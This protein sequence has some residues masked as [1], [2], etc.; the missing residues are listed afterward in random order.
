MKLLFIT[1]KMDSQDTI[2]GFV[3]N[4]VS[5]FA[6]DWSQIDVICLEKGDISSLPDSVKVFSLGKEFGRSRLKYFKKFFYYVLFKTHRYDAVFVHM[7]QEYILLAGWWWWLKGKKVYLWRNHHAGSFLTD[8]AVFFCDKVFCTSK[9]SYT[10]K[11]KKTILMPVGIDL[12]KFYPKEGLA[13]Q[14]GSIL[15]LS[16]IS[17]VKKAHILLEA[18][19]LVAKEGYSFSANFYGDTL[20]KDKPYREELNDL[21]KKYNLEK[22]VEF[23]PGVPNYLTPDLYNKH[24]LFINLSS[25]GMYDKTIFEALA[26]GCPVLACNLNLI[27]QIDSDFIFEEDDITDLSSK[28]SNLIEMPSEILE[29][30]VDKARDFVLKMHSLDRLRQEIKKQIDYA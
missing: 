17:P 26:C 16:R 12:D 1:Q 25:S 11:F 24:S 7:N 9:F 6:L 13:K 21:R 28:I 2:L 3:T 5:N 18:L 29:C 14:P 4:W 19:G 27:N 22:R 20:A 15:F 8:L 10:A 30:K 23:L